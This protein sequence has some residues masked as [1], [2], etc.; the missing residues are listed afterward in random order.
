M[1]VSPFTQGIAEFH[2]NQ[3]QHG[4]FIQVGVPAKPSHWLHQIPLGIVDH[5]TPSPLHGG[6]SWFRIRQ[7]HP[8]TQSKLEISQTSMEADPFFHSGDSSDP[9]GIFLGLG[10]A[11]DRKILF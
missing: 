10:G 6:A 9:I 2:K 11:M 8:Q 3:A 7:N 5:L 1:L 4:E